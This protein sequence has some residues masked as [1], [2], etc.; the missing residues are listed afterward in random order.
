[1]NNLKLILAIMNVVIIMQV[2]ASDERLRSRTLSSEIMKSMY[3]IAQEK[4]N[5]DQTALSDLIRTFQNNSMRTFLN[6]PSF[7]ADHR[8]TQASVLSKVLIEQRTALDV[9]E[10]I[11]QNNLVQVARSVLVSL[12]NYRSHPQKVSHIINSEDFNKLETMSRLIA[13]F[14]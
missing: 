7:R 11:D 2:H 1:M 12:E 10:V 8:Y 5:T 4:Q 3:K 13:N 9:T 6:S 14:E